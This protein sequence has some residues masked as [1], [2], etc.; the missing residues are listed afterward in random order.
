MPNFTLRAATKCCF[1][2]AV[3]GVA[4]AALGSPC[5]AIPV[6]AHRY[7]LAC[8]TC[9]TT[10][11]HL[12]SFG[13]QFRKG[14]FSLPNGRGVFPVAVKV[15]LAFGTDKDPTGLPKAIVDEVELL[16]GG[17]LGKN[18]NYFLEQ[19]VID[20]GRPGLTRDAWLQFH[21]ATGSTKIGQF[22][23]P[24][25]VEVE[26]ERDTLTHY[27]LYDQTVGINTFN[28]FDPRMGVD[29]SFGSDDGL[30]VHLLALHAYD[31]QT[32]TPRSGID[33]MASVSKTSGGFT[34]QT[35]RYQGQRHFSVAD[36]FWRQGYALS[37]Q[38]GKA[39]VTAVLQAGN[40]TSADG[41]GTQAR[42]SGGF[43]QMGYRF[44]DAFATVAR[45]E[46]TADDLSGLQRR[47]VLGAIL[48]PRRNMRITTETQMNQGHRSA[49]VGLLFA[50]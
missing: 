21:S 30:L 15:N 7:A 27:A 5:W 12:N 18:T 28:F 45:Y 24:L 38:S 8:Q 40:D 26:S 16:S 43:L 9:H 14:G 20:G 50:Y 34:L 35:Y 44:T 33:V 36:R 13:R 46:G 48:R 37:M 23:L 10:V 1:F 42:S 32:P 17:T 3:V 11:P 22:E 47:F 25:P 2:F 19:Y 49:N 4:F 39:D 6:F 29:A 41:A 31:R